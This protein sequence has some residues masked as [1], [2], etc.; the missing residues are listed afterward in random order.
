MMRQTQINSLLRSQ[1]RFRL[2]TLVRNEK[3]LRNII[4]NFKKAVA[5][6]K[7]VS[8]KIKVTIKVHKVSGRMRIR[9]S[10][11][12]SPYWYASFVEQPKLDIKI[13]TDFKR[14]S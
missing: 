4:E 10:R 5:G 8:A 12:P 6:P 2:F 3:I 11:D 1:G 9:L 14:K 7:I 13:S